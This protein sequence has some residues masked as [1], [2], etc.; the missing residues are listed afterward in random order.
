MKVKP[1]GEHEQTDVTMPGAAG[2]RMRMLIGDVFRRNAEVVPRR[3]AAS[4]F[5]S[6]RKRPTTSHRAGLTTGRRSHL[7]RTAVV[8]STCGRFR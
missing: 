5:R 8:T 3:V 6:R 7:L 4:R 2:T 1:I